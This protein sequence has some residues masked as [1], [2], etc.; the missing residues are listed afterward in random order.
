MQRSVTIDPQNTC[1]SPS[2]HEMTGVPHYHSLVLQ[3]DEV[4]H[5]QQLLTL[6]QEVLHLSVC[7][8]KH[9]VSELL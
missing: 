7:L 4:L 6:K 2:A 1:P 9:P 8:A 5:Q 3:H